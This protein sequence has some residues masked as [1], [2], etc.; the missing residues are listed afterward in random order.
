MKFHSELDMGVLENHIV[1]WTQEYPCIQKV[2]IF[3]PSYE[4]R[5]DSQKFIIVCEV[6][7][8]P[9]PTE[10][11]IQNL[12]EQDVFRPQ[13]TLYEYYRWAGSETVSTPWHIQSDIPLFYKSEIDLSKRSVFDEWVWITLN[14]GEENNHA[15]LTHWVDCKKELPLFQLP[16]GQYN[17][18]SQATEKIIESKPEDFPELNLH[19]LKKISERWVEKYTARKVSFNKITLYRYASPSFGAKVSTTYAIVFDISHYEPS[20]LPDAGSSP[21]EHIALICSESHPDPYSDF[22]HDLG[23]NSALSNGLPQGMSFGDFNVVYN[24]PRIKGDGFE[25]EWKLIPFYKGAVLTDQIRVNEGG[26]VLYDSNSLK[27]AAIPSQKRERATQRVVNGLMLEDFSCISKDSDLKWQGIT[28]TVLED[29][30]ILFQFKDQGIT[31]DFKQLGFGNQRNGSPIKAW[32]ILIEMSRH[33]G[34]IPYQNSQRSIIEKRAG[35]IRAKLKNLFP[36]VGDDPFPIDQND[37]VYRL[38]IHIKNNQE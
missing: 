29:R 9:G 18:L 30:E 3:A 33:G 10:D 15:I 25:R 17:P 35:E 38:K 21:K 7:P 19:H 24:P 1:H 5:H 13:H 20:F 2:S 22:I 34:C 32:D 28:A 8:D 6:P 26:I 4:R 36:N 11:D 14:P 31:K 37:G 23:Y 27:R 12:T 16:R